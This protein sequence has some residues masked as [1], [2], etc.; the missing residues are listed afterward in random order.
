MKIE[1]IL[2]EFKTETDE[3]ILK[4]ILE[5]DSNIKELKKKTNVYKNTFSEFGS[6]SYYELS[7]IKKSTIAILDTITRLEC[8]HSVIDTLRII[9]G[10]KK[11][12]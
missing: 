6:P 5:L 7:K 10:R 1:K 9:E 11:F 3:Y 4:E 8:Q 12:E 2:D